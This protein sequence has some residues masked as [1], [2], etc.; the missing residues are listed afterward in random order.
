VKPEFKSSKQRPEWFQRSLNQIGELHQV[1]DERLT[2][3]NLGESYLKGKLRIILVLR[4]PLL[5]GYGE[6]CVAVID[7]APTREATREQRPG[8]KGWD[9]ALDRNYNKV[10][11]RCYEKLVFISDVKHVEAPEP[12][13]VPSLVRLYCSD[14]I[15][16]ARIGTLYFS[17]VLN[18]FKFFDTVGDRERGLLGDLSAPRL[19]KLTGEIV[20]AR[21]QTMDSVAQDREKTGRRIDGDFHLE[22]AITGL[23]IVI[24]NGAIGV[25]LAEG[26]DRHI[27]I[28]DVLFGPFNLG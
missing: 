27:Q 20:K 6:E 19:D 21:P 4:R 24:A 28:K 18:G 5:A 25:G 15:N 8:K 9:D 23:G 13:A 22:H 14:E 10:D 17:K 12:L 3:E 2:F 7:R 16:S 1:W 26:F 11:S